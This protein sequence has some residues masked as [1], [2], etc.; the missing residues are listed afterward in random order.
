M[1]EGSTACGRLVTLKTFFFLEGGCSTIFAR[2]GMCFKGEVVSTV[3]GMADA[4]FWI[5]ERRKRQR[6]FQDDE[7][8]TELGKP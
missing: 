5:S 6:V 7:V 4:M 1:V 8:S 3:E 2:C